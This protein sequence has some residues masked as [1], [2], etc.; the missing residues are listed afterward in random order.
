ME[1]LRLNF[2]DEVDSGLSV[3]LFQGLF[4]RFLEVLDERVGEL[5]GSRN[6]EVNL[7]LVTD[8][9]IRLINRDFRGK[10]KA[11][12]VISC[13]YLEDDQLVSGGEVVA[14]GD[15]YISVETAKRQADEKNHSLKKEMQILFVHGLLHL[16][17]FDHQND[18]EEEEM[19]KWAK[20]ILGY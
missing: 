1:K 9:N 3:S 18:E 8:E 11:T 19:E 6:G 16:F 7:A 17:G 4:G 20:E 5:L 13:A 12:D 2:T 15:M 14:A 10:D